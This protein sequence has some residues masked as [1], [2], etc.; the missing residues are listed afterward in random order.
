LRI[1][2]DYKDRSERRYGLI[3]RAGISWELPLGMLQ[4]RHRT[5]LRNK[6]KQKDHGPPEEAIAPH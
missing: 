5:I 2:P 6:N 1:L 4:S 3:R